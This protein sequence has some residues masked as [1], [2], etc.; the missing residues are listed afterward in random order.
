MESNPA[1]ENFLFD[2]TSK[3]GSLTRINDINNS[4]DNLAPLHQTMYRIMCS[5]S[6]YIRDIY[7]HKTTNCWLIS[8]YQINT[9]A[10]YFSIWLYC[11][12]RWTELRQVTSAMK[13]I[14]SL[15]EVYILVRSSN[16]LLLSTSLSVF[17]NY[18]YLKEPSNI[19][20]RIPM[21]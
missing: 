2:F 5:Q 11:I 20:G 21:L 14:F 12:H 17:T 15:C 7:V 9:W 6:R 19:A 16:L 18:P 4:D 3:H 13:S 10:T 8:K 1:E